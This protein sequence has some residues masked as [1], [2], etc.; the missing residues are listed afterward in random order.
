MIR[1]ISL[2]NVLFFILSFA[3]FLPSSGLAQPLENNTDRWG[4]DLNCIYPVTSPEECRDMCAGTEGCQAF[5]WV[6]PRYVR[7]EPICCLKNPVPAPS[8]NKC[9]VSG[10]IAW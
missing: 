4:S 3:S 10:V 9:C 6:R 5:T 2:V 8:P 7:N 1:H